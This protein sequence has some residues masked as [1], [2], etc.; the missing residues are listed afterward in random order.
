MSYDLY[1]R[2]RKKAVGKISHPLMFKT[3]SKWGVEGKQLRMYDKPL[4]DIIQNGEKL[5]TFPLMSGTR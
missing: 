5:K 4:A 3:L 2:C 1:D